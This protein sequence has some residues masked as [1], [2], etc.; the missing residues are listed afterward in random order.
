MDYVIM[1]CDRFLNATG[2][3]AHL[4]LKAKIVCAHALLII[5]VLKKS[6]LVFVL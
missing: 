4:I 2:T 6:L 1:S 3:F 5:F